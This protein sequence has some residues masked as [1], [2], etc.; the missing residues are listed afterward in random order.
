M[1]HRKKGQPPR[2]ISLLDEPG[3]IPEKDLKQLPENQQHR[4]IQQPNYDITDSIYDWRDRFKRFLNMN[5]N[6][7]GG[8]VLMYI[9]RLEKELGID[10]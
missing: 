5:G 4:V 9:K 2:A 6:P 3:F 1:G 7:S 10:D 8:F